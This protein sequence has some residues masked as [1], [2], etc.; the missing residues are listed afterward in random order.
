MGAPLPRGMSHAGSHLP[1]PDLGTKVPGA[2]G[3]PAGGGSQVPANKPNGEEKSTDV[4]D[5]AL[6]D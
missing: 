4:P 6:I 5:P 3:K 2:R 1:V